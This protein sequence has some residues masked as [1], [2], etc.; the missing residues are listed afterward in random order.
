ML[1]SHQ[2][3]EPVQVVITYDNAPLREFVDELREALRVAA[4]DVAQFA[5][6]ILVSLL[7]RP[8]AFLVLFDVNHNSTTGADVIF[9]IGP[10]DFGR[11]LLAALAGKVDRGAV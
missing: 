5:Q 6:Q 2:V 9:T 8:Q 4:P 7:N 11:N 3:S 1:P 10:S